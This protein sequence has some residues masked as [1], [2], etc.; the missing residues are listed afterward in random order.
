MS[1]ENIMAK[2]IKKIFWRKCNSIG[3]FPKLVR[4]D[5]MIKFS[6]INIGKIKTK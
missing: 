6:K 5:D 4:F 2:K 3:Y 1:D